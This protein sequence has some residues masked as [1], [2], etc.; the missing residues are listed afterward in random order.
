MPGIYGN[1]GITPTTAIATVVQ[2]SPYAVAV[3]GQ[4]YE[5][6]DPQTW[7]PV[8]GDTVLVDYLPCSSQFVIVAIV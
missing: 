5:A 4:V 3:A 2:D 1:E 8:V 7:A 6:V